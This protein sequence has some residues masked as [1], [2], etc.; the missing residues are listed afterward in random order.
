MRFLSTAF[1]CCFPVSRSVRPW[2]E[3]GCHEEPDERAAEVKYQVEVGVV[4]LQRAAGLDLSVALRDESAPVGAQEMGAAEL[5]DL[6]DRGE[7][8]EA[9][10]C[11]E[12]A[13]AL[14]SY[15]QPEDEED[16]EAEACREMEVFVIAKAE[17]HRREEA[18]DAKTVEQ[19]D[20]EDEPVY[21]ERHPLRAREE[22]ERAYRAKE[23]ERVE[24][25]VE[26]HEERGG[27]AEAGGEEQHRREDDFLSLNEP[28]FHGTGYLPE[29]INVFSQLTFFQGGVPIR[30]LS[31]RGLPR[32]C[33]A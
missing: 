7:P 18:E 13:P 26:R 10:D 12:E 29:A 25:I 9:Q 28:A 5:D 27:D 14:V 2:A 4:D 15:R 16:G 33:S 17:R 6:S 11:D 20:D 22:E 3:N 32:P 19:E 1:S 23:E 31:V 8:H 21:D 24:E 30:F